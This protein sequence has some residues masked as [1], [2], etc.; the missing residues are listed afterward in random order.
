MFFVD[1]KIMSFILYS[2]EFFL[3]LFA[4]FFAIFVR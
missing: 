4:Y 2:N 3:F 1:N